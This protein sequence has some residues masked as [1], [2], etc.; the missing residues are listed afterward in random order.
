LKK[1]KKFKEDLLE[2]RK[3]KIGKM[4]RKKSMK[5]NLLNKELILGKKKL[6]NVK[7]S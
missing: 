2:I 7:T 3:D 4:N 6:L 5:R 1:C